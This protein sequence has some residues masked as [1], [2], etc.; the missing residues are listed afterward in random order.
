MGCEASGCC[1]SEIW[2]LL[3][4]VN[5]AAAALG[6]S[7]ATFLRA[8]KTDNFQLCRV[9]PCKLAHVLCKMHFGKIRCTRAE[10][11]A[12][13]AGGCWGSEGWCLQWRDAQEAQSGSCLAAQ[14]QSALP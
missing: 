13:E 7:A 5:A 12:G 2:Q 3:V 11:F 6:D 10:C 9:K 8:A 14:P 4:E 1:L